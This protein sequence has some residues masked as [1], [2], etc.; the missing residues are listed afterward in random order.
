MGWHGKLARGLAAHFPV[1]KTIDDWHFVNQLNQSRAIAT[2]IEHFR[3]HRG[4]CMGTIVWQLND[5][6]PV[7]SWAAIDGYGR[8]KP[9]WYTLRRV[10][11][12]QLLTV[13][14]REGGLNIVTVN[15]AQTSWTTTVLVQRVDADGTV[16][17]AWNATVCTEPG[18]VAQLPI[19]GEITAPGDP[20]REFLVVTAGGQRA[21]WFFVADKDFQ[22]PEPRYDVTIGSGAEPTVTVTAQ[23]VLRDVIL[24]AD[25]LHPAAQVDDMLITL[26][27]GESHVFRI[28]GVNEL[29]AT[30]ISPPVLRSANDAVP[31]R[32]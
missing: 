6:W 15:D 13:Q 2:G 28:S 17:A 22:Y 27:P 11:Q 23:S 25:R 26:L 31:A 32:G 21:T 20:R 4:T 7:T 29:S 18:S 24:F 14:P 30:D 1:P 3:S 8:V 12:P 9:L 16:P 10:Y 5:C 19:P